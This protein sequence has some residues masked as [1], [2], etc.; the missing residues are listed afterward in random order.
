MCL[1]L[2]E[3]SGHQKAYTELLAHIDDGHALTL[4][5]VQHE[6]IRFSR[7]NP[8]PRSHSSSSAG[9]PRRTFSA[10]AAP[11]SA[12]WRDLGLDEHYH[13]FAAILQSNRVSPHQVLPDADID[14]F[15]HPDAGH[16]LA[17]AAADYPDEIPSDDS[18]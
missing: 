11:V 10:T 14:S 12:Y 8:S 15:G 1:Y 2:S 16:A 17:R 3:A 5:T 7:S 4:D 13:T 9:S 18:A 6:I